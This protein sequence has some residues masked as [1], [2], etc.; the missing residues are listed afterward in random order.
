VRIDA[1]AIAKKRRALH[2][3]EDGAAI[4]VSGSPLCFVSAGKRCRRKPKAGE[5]QKK[6]VAEDPRR[7]FEPPCACRLYLAFSAELVSALPP[8]E[9]SWPAPAIVLQPVATMAVPTTKSKAI[10]RVM[11]VLLVE[12]ASVDVVRPGYAS[13][14]GL[15]PVSRFR[16]G[17]SQW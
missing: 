13:R 3:R 17:L 5:H 8:L 10:S 6:P 1:R 11:K 15:D 9:M 14:S 16:T 12:N 7:A 4:H 2:C